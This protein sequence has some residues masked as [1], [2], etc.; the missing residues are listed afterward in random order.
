[1]VGSDYSLADLGRNWNLYQW[2]SLKTKIGQTNGL[3]IT[4][5]NSSPTKIDGCKGPPY[6]EMRWNEE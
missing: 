1:M 3:V 5:S 6:N 4:I 2:P